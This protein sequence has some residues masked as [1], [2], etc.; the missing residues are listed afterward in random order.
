MN[1]PN[2]SP[3][4]WVG[5]RRV[6]ILLSV[7]VASAAPGCQ[8]PAATP[9]ANPGPETKVSTAPAPDAREAVR[10]DPDQQ[11]LD[12][13]A[14]MLQTARTACDNRDAN[15]FIQA[16][17]FSPGAAR[18]FIAPTV[19]TGEAGFTRKVPGTSYPGLPIGMIDHRW[20]TAESVQRL[21]THG[22]GPFERVQ[23]EVNQSSSNRIRVEWRTVAGDEAIEGNE[24][25]V[26]TSYAVGPAGSLLFIPTDGCWALIEDIRIPGP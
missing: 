26:D 17:A 3:T 24:D 1:R 8:A 20:V 5:S 12:T 23:V 10:S 7:I 2:N 4:A 25:S 16:I 13:E 19:L 22:T 14:V 11:E 15:S 9:A 6:A 18:R 21:A